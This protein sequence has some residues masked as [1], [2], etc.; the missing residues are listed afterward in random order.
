MSFLD[1]LRDVFLFRAQRQ[2]RLL[3][4]AR[5]MDLKSHDFARLVNESGYAGAPLRIE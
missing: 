5:E 4:S 3:P 1:R 2:S